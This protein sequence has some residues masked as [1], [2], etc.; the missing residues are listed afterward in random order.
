MADVYLPVWAVTGKWAT[1]RVR[2][3]VRGTARP[4]FDPLLSRKLLRQVM[5]TELVALGAGERVENTHPWAPS[6]EGSN[7][8]EEGKL[9]F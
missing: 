3:V 4:L 7:S 2:V 1:R 6:P 9:R 5:G 8:V